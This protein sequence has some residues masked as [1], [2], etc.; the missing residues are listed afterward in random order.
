MPQLQVVAIEGFP[1]LNFRLFC[2]RA[3]TH[4]DLASQITRW[5][6][7]EASD[8]QSGMDLHAIRHIVASTRN[9]L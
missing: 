8:Y 6:A 9:C 3:I 7:I 4:G 1:P 5:L 2:T